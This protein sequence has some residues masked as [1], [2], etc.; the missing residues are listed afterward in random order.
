MP[1]LGARSVSYADFGGGWMGTRNLDTDPKFVDAAHGDYRSEI[2][3][4]DGEYDGIVCG[5]CLKISLSG[6]I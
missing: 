5:C 2:Q 1:G 4:A 6:P 3:G